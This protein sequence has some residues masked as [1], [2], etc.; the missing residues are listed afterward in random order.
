MNEIF[1][2]D[3][4]RRQMSTMEKVMDERNRLLRS[5]Y[6]SRVTALAV[7]IGVAWVAAYQLGVWAA[8]KI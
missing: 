1:A 6:I 3:E 4:L 8:G 2:R 5:R 7:W